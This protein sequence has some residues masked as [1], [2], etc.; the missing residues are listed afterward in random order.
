MQAWVD[1][2]DA[3]PL[4]ALI[5][6]VVDR[7]VANVSTARV[8]VLSRFSIENYWLDSFLVFGV[9]LDN[10]TAP[11]VPGLAISTGDEHLVRGLAMSKLQGIVD[12]IRSPLEVYASTAMVTVDTSLQTVSFTNGVTLSYPAWMLEIG[13]A[14]V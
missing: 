1:K 7:D 9:L 11:T 13:R 3:A 10:G 6:G 5:R 12:A 4:D 14:H 2:F 8:K